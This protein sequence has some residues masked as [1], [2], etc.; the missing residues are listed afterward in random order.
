MV[1]DICLLRVKKM[2]RWIIM[3]EKVSDAE[4]E[5]ENYWGKK[6]FK[7]GRKAAWRGVWGDAKHLRPVHENIHS[8]RAVKIK[9]TT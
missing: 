1:K 4:G 6:H 8:W 3:L 9:V 2:R 5:I 7:V